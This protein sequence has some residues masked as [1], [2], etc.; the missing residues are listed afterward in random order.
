VKAIVPNSL[1]FRRWVYLFCIVDV[2]YWQDNRYFTFVTLVTFALK[3][4]VDA[5]PNIAL[6]AIVKQ[7]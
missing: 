2:A 6:A 1:N 4:F 5:N 7:R 3:F